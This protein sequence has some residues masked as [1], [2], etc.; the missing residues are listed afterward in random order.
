MNTDFTRCGCGETTNLRTVAM[1]DKLWREFFSV[2]GAKRPL[3][4]T[5]CT[6][7]IADW[8]RYAAPLETA[9]VYAY[10]CNACGFHSVNYATADERDA[11]VDFSCC[12]YARGFL[13]TWAEQVT[14][15]T[16][17]LGRMTTMV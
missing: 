10:K 5:A 16:A 14:R 6:T 12:D 17:P 2:E 15:F 1:T 8:N 9:Y 7:C 3:F 13:S 4:A 11:A